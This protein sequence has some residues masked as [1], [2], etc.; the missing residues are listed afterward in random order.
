MRTLA[1]ELTMPRNNSANG[2]WSGDSKR[3]I[4]IVRVGATCTLKDVGSFY[5]DFGD[6]WGANVSVT[7]V[8]GQ[9]IR[10]LRKVSDGFCGYDWMIDEIRFEG[11]IKTLEERTTKC[12]K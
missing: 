1:F 7:E 10:K 12:K 6:G 9:E 3:H 2:R 5:Y 4:R 11:R 8:H